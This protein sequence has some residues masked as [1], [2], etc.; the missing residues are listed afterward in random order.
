MHRPAKVGDLQLSL[1]ADQQ[2]LR[3]DVAVDDVLGVAVHQR[4]SQRRYI[5]A[6]TLGNVSG[7]V[8]L[9]LQASCGRADREDF[10]SLKCCLACSSR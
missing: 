6:C 10:C 2:V 7:I 5:P 1:Q 3:L 8:Q 9:P 4:T